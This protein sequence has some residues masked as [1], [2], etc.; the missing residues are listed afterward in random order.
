MTLFRQPA[1]D[2]GPRNKKHKKIIGVDSYGWIPG[3]ARDDKPQARDDKPQARDD[4]PQVRND[5]TNARDDGG[6]F[7]MAVPCSRLTS[8]RTRH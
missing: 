8:P 1:L 5:D 6:E 3:Q 2:A 7:R 4:K